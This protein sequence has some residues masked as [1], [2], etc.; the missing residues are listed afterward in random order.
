MQPP[1][2]L[3]RDATGPACELDASI[4]PFSDHPDLTIRRRE[5]ALLL[6]ADYP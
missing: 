4:R 1:P 6:S 2:V 3:G 5:S